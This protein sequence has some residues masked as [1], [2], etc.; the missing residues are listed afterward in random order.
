MPDAEN[1]TRTLVVVNPAAGGGR[2]EARWRAVESAVRAAFP[3]D[4]HYTTAPGD[5]TVVARQAAGTGITRVLAV[6]GDGTLHELVNGLAGSAVAL[7]VLPVGTGN[8]FARASGFMMPAAALIAGLAGCHRRRVDLGRVAG[9]YYI[10]VAGVGFD[11]HVAATVNAMA[12][13]RGGTLPYVGTA[14]RE[15]F[16][17]RPPLLDVWADGAQI[18][19][20]SPCL[21]VAVG[22]TSAYGGGM[23]IC[24]GARFDDGEL[25]ALL[26]GDVFGWQT[27][28]L[29]PRV[30]VGRHLG[31]PGVRLQ[32]ARRVRIEGPAHIQLHAD[33]EVV[34]GLPAEFEVAPAALTLW[35]PHAGSA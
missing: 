35:T 29:L 23:R 25:D 18:V 9:R 20:H 10:N 30:F 3:F 32:R 17:Y 19:R 5:A 28:G 16:R 24:P 11:A 1:H 22:N 33:G 31:H 21:L 4:L 8:D 12:S 34:G 15:A 27:V 6:G 13:K 7:G 14:L 2:S 26:V